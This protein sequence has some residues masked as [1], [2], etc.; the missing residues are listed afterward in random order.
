MTETA[1]VFLELGGIIALLS[2]L[3]RL[4]SRLSISP[5]PLYLLGGLMFGEGGLVPVVTSE[6]FVEVG[7]EVGVVILL[8]MLG[9]EYS[10]RELVSSLRSSAT[11][12]VL[13]F[14]LNFSPGL[15]L[16]LFLGMELVPSM[17]LGGVTYI[18]STGV[19]AKLLNDLGWI[20]N[21][22]TPLVLSVLVFEDL[23]IAII[24]PIL[25]A[26]AFGSSLGTAVTSVA[27]ALIGVGLALII[28]AKYGHQLSD[29]AFSGSNEVNL[30]TLLGITLIVAGAA[31]AIHLSAAVGAF[32]VGIAVSGE[33]AN[34]A[35]VQLAPI[36]DL[37][38][39]FFFVFFGL[40]TD[41]SILPGVAVPVLVLVVVTMF[42]KLVVA[43]VA[44]Q[45][46][47]IRIRGRLRAA[48]LLAARGE[49][50][51]IIASLGVAAGGGSRLEAIAAGYVLVTATLGP[52]LARS[53][54]RRFVSV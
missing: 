8:L 6:R 46:A 42:T 20:G 30:L 44:G 23:A 53:I 26:L 7:A 4:A 21:R 24:L 27:I 48:T 17:F 11:V 1:S 2:L 14:V 38:A 41:P 50:S 13:D 3:G 35:E 33:A 45:R 36:R 22:E 19:V 28:S 16:G 49:F 47:G 34:R 40:S 37:F 51:V 18:S 15:L 12:G 39:A 5:I 25:S 31:D 32:L 43:W 54:D 10:G 52:V 9:L 29:R